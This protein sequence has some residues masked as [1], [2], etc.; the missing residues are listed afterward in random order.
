[1]WGRTSATEHCHKTLPDLQ[2]LS[3]T[4]QLLCEKSVLRGSL[5]RLEGNCPL[6]KASL[7]DLDGDPH[8]RNFSVRVLG[9]SGKQ[10]PNQ[11]IRWELLCE[12]SWAR[13]LQIKDPHGVSL[14]SRVSCDNALLA[15]VT[16][17][18]HVG[19]GKEQAPGTDFSSFIGWC[20]PRRGALGHAEHVSHHHQLDI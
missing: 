18:L 10:L 15:E 9:A 14:F 6:R 20:L 19:L 11:T 13:Q 2:G 8:S 7:W 5:P 16:V 4:E 17:N 3:P 1:M 12:V